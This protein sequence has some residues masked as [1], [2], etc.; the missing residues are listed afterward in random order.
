MIAFVLSIVSSV[1]NS[2]AQ[3]STE[4]MDILN[5]IYLYGNN[6]FSISNNSISASRNT[7]NY[8]IANT[9]TFLPPSCVISTPTHAITRQAT[10]WRA[11]P[12]TSSILCYLFDSIH[13]HRVLINYTNPSTSNTIAILD[14]SGT[15]L[16]STTTSGTQLLDLNLFSPYFVLRFTVASGSYVDINMLGLPHINIT[17]IDSRAYTYIYNNEYLTLQPNASRVFTPIITSSLRVVLRYPRVINPNGYPL[18]LYVYDVSAQAFRFKEL[19]RVYDYTFIPANDDEAKMMYYII[20]NKGFVAANAS[21]ISLPGAGR[22][23]FQTTPGMFYIWNTSSLGW[24]RF[25]KSV[26]GVREYLTTYSV[27][28]TASRVYLIVQGDGSIYYTENSTQYSA[29]LI[30][31]SFL[32]PNRQ[33]TINNSIFYNSTEVYRLTT[34]YTL[35]SSN[36]SSITLNTSNNTFIISFNNFTH[37]FNRLQ[38]YVGQ[39]ATYSDPGG[40][41]NVTYR[42]YTIPSSFTINVTAM[43]DTASLSLQN[44]SIAFASTAYGK[45]LTGWAGCTLENVIHTAWWITRVG[46][47]ISSIQINF[48]V[49]GASISTSNTSTNITALINLNNESLVGCLSFRAYVGWRVSVSINNNVNVSASY[50]VTPTPFITSINPTAS[51]NSFTYVTTQMLQQY[52]ESLASD[53]SYAH[54]VRFRNYVAYVSNPITSV[55]DVKAVGRPNYFILYNRDGAE[56]YAGGRG[57]SAYYPKVYGTIVIYDLV[58]DAM[59][60][61]EKLYGAGAEGQ[62][63]NFTHTYTYTTPYVVVDVPPSI[64]TAI[65]SYYPF[66]LVFS[67]LIIIAAGRNF[68]SAHLIIASAIIAIVILIAPLPSTAVR[69]ASLMTIVI[70]ASLAY[71]FRRGSR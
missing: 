10:V 58:S 24:A 47:S 46:G 28:D 18:T 68:S 35:T 7:V 69:L 21:V 30:S 31:Y 57:D 41:I 8:T 4:I 50:A 34:I 43:S 71:E 16:L 66:F 14:R 37:T 70:L 38:T 9:A 65:S 67:L 11:G 51:G 55:F 20:N 63:W 44:H 25:Y 52:S 23:G 15:T 12:G 39:S 60:S 32:T 17:N 13:P 5:H 53:I 54:S 40:S 49:G 56:V 61:Y 27:N 45:E 22:T 26:G 19:G 62:P 64:S 33:L 59:L 42:L 6:F 2:N 29:P 48:F 3:S 36:V 1:I